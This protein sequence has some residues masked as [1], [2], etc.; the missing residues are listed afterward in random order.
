MALEVGPTTTPQN[1]K[2]DPQPRLQSDWLRNARGQHIAAHLTNG[3]G[4]TGRLVG[5]DQFCIALQTAD[6]SEPILIF[7]HAVACL[8]RTPPR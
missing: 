7:K 1:A 2:G 4:I 6:Q 8:V 5:F 3:K